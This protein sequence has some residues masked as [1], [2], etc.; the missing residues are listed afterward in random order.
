MQL[1]NAL[2]FIIILLFYETYRNNN[3]YKRLLFTKIYTILILSLPKKFS[4]K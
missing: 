3:S 2:S 4:N 1:L